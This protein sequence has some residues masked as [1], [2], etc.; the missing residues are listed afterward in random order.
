MVGSV[1]PALGPVT[2]GTVR[3]QREMDALTLLALNLFPSYP[4]WNPSLRDGDAHAQDGI[5]SS[6]NPSW[7]FPEWCDC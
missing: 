3:M 4:V 1:A 5:C 2:L 7:K 6:V